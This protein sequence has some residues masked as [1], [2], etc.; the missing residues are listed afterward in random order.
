MSKF[1]LLANAGRFADAF[2]S[3]ES[4]HH[5]A[6]ECR[7]CEDFLLAGVQAFHWIK[8]ADTRFR[9]AL[10]KDQVSVADA[11]EIEAEL[12]NYIRTWSQ[13]SHDADDWV[14]K[15][16][17][18]HFKVEHLAEFEKCK[19]EVAS[20][21]SFWDSESRL[22]ENMERLRD[23]AIAEHERGETHEFI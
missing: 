19:E 1:P 2:N 12:E 6:M 22:S 23:D 13:K 11:L 7:D 16:K 21:I 8:S 20:M 4:H 9:S 14:K 5:E 18:L 15:L 17:S 3:W 10:Y